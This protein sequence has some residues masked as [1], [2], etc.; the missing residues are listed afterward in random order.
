MLSHCPER[1]QRSSVLVRINGG[2][3]RAVCDAKQRR[4]WQGHE[5][6]RNRS[7]EQAI[8]PA[9]SGTDDTGDFL[10][11]GGGSVGQAHPVGFGKG[12]GGCPSIEL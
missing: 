6:P 9:D 12:L 11:C 3:H 10:P 4:T 2:Q 1:T 7:L 5:Y 8:V